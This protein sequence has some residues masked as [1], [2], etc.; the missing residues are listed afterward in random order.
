MAPSALHLRLHLPDP[1][2]TTQLGRNLAEHSGPGDTLLL[3]GQ[4]G[5]GKSHLA[6]AIIKALVGEDEEVPS[7]TYTL[8]QTYDAPLCEIWHADLY[9][10][11]DPSEVVELGLDEAWST[12]IC[13]IEWPDRLGDA[14]PADALTISLAEEGEGRSACLAA[15]SE[16]WARLDLPSWEQAQ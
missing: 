11:S 8:V 10:L 7:P 12:A 13:L 15:S 4:I 16:R 3:E 5:A 1:A 14:A 2:A 9:R 6:R